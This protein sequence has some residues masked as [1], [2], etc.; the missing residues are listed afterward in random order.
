MTK[1]QEEKRSNRQFAPS[2]RPEEKPTLEDYESDDKEEVT[3]SKI[4]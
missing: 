3:K 1:E 4:E 2:E